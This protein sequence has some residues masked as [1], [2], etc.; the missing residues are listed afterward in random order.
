M[1]SSFGKLFFHAVC[2]IC[3]IFEIDYTPNLLSDANCES[4]RMEKIYQKRI[5]CNI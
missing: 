2:E 1:G 5:I 4:K 3:Q